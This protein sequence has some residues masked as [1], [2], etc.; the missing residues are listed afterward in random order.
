V[1]VDEFIESSQD[2]MM[3]VCKAYMKDAFTRDDL[4][5]ESVL[6]LLKKRDNDRL[7]DI[8]ERGEG[9]YWY[10]A[11]V[12]RMVTGTKSKFH[13]AY[14]SRLPIERSRYISVHEAMDERVA[15]RLQLIDEL[16]SKKPWYKRQL[17]KLHFNDCYSFTK[18]AEETGIS[19]KSLY[20]EIDKLKREVEAHLLKNGTT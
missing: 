7:Q 14:I 3:N 8:I 18:L 19:R 12:K 16:I 15:K 11:T 6:I 9:M 4:F 13:K 17:W 5:Q 2:E 1:N 20:N 10:A